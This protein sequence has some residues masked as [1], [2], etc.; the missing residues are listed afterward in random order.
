MVE[1][2]VTTERLVLRRWRESDRPAF[3][4]LNA[5]PQVMATIG[6]PMSSEQSDAF[7]DRIEVGFDQHGFGLWCVELDGE[8]I[9]FT[10]LS[11]PWFRDGVEVGWRIRS[12]HWGRGYAPEAATACLGV[13]FGQLG[14]DEVISFTAVTNRNSQ[15]VM[16]KIGLTRDPEADFDHPSVPEG[17]P[18]R[19]HVLYRIT[20]AAWA[21]RSQP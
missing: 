3:R 20:Q 6:P 10:G 5:D 12:E 19:P 9:G 18:L 1:P 4:A 17:N 2:V 11:V 7:M 16:A 15:R 14:F 8:P 13:A 21:L